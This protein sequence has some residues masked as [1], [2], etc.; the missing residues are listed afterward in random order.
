MRS[1]RRGRGIEGARALGDHFSAGGLG[2]ALI[3]IC[4]HIAAQARADGGVFLR[5]N[6]LTKRAL[7]E[8]RR[9]NQE[10]RKSSNPRLCRCMS[11]FHHNSGM[12]G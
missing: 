7:K 1:L 2:E 3:G 12:E 10:G 8:R 6:L 5:A 9:R 11:D 4:R